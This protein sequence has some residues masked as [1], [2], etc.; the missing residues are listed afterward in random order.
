MEVDVAGVEER[1]GELGHE[2]ADAEGKDGRQR[3][4]GDQDCSCIV[5]VLTWENGVTEEG[6]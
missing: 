2:E 1:G 6:G 4:P 3:I 5:A